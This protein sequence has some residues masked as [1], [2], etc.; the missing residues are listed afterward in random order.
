MNKLFLLSLLV[1]DVV[2]H[3]QVSGFCEVLECSDIPSAAERV[4]VMGDTASD[5]GADLGQG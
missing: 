2:E 1:I 5:L 4:H 3:P